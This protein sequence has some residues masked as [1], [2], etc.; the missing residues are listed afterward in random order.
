MRADIARENEVSDAVLDEH[1]SPDNSSLP[2]LSLFSGAGGLDY[3]FKAAGFRTV[4]AIDINQAALETYETN[5]PGSAVIPLDLSQTD[6]QTVVDT[7][8]EHSRGVSP[9]GIIGGPPCQGFSSANVHQ[10]ADDPRRQLLFKYADIVES[11][12]DHFDIGFFAFENV[13]GLASRRHKKLLADFNRMCEEAGFAITSSIIEAG[14]FGIAQHRKRLVVV[15]LNKDRYPDAE[16]QLAGGNSK[17]RRVD[18]VLTDLPE[19]TFCARDLKPDDIPH[20]PNHVAM[21]PR[22]HRFT[23]GSLA[24]GNGKG[25]SFKVL[26]WG[27]P[28]YTVAY[29]H[30]EVHVHPN[31]HRRLSVYEAM[32]LQGFPRDGYYLKG[33]FTDQVR[34][35]S[36]AVPPPLGEGIANSILN[37]IRDQLAEVENGLVEP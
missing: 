24:P 15:G 25:L 23:D 6:P 19:P 5:H 26:S 35:I 28:S 34:L 9:V 13:P 4:L 10:E 27:A 18:E 33:S 22:S 1:T 21:N 11:F 29:G 8:E 16:L 37:A 30:N 36:D 31:C 12:K 32:L 7:W 3:G 2:L 20:H 17:P 14:T